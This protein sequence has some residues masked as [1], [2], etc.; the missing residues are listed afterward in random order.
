MSQTT[1]YW[2]C[3][4]CHTAVDRHAVQCP[5]C[6]RPHPTQVRGIPALRLR[7][8]RL[9]IIAGIG[10]GLLVGIPLVLTIVVA[11]INWLK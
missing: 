9:A 6:G 3:H 11:T 1:K 8:R 4:T 10:L 7:A 5:R 2:A